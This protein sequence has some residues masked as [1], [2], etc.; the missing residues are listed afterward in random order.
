MKPLTPASPHAIIMVGVPGSGKS[1]FAEHFADTF[2]APIFNRHKLQKEL[3]LDTEQINTLQDQ[4]TA[5][6]MKT[7][8][9]FI[10]EGGSER[11]ADRVKLL[12]AVTKAGYQPLL[13]WV[14][15]DPSEAQ[16]RA[17]RKYPTGSGLSEDEFKSLVK[18]FQAP[19]QTE[20]P[21]VISGRH[22]Y[23]SQLKVVLRQLALSNGRDNA[24]KEAPKPPQRPRGRGI[25]VR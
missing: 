22:T 24:P 20:K 11:R 5:E 2:Q 12:Q 14:Q 15:T 1:T 21:L 17:L 13:V 8:R 6:Y 16:R 19:I 23:A 10:I 18:K 25:I 4:I 7:H 3:S 9:T